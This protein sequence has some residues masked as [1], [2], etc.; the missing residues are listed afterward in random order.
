M[1]PESPRSTGRRVAVAALWTAILCLPWLTILCWRISPISYASESLGYRYFHSYRILNGDAST[2]WE[3]QGQVLG[4]FHNGL[5]LLIDRV[6]LTD[7]PGLRARLDLFAHLTLLANA[8]ALGSV[9]LLAARSRRILLVDLVTM[10]SVAAF[11]VFAWGGGFLVSY[12]PDYYVFEVSA[13]CAALGLALE[14]MR[15]SPRDLGLRRGILLGV[16]AAVLVALK[17]TLVPVALLPVVVMLARTPNPRARALLVA[18]SGWLVGLAAGA[19]LIV[20]AFYCFDFVVIKR[21]FASWLRYV[22]HPGESEPG[23]WVTWLR[24]PLGAGS[25]PWDDH[26]YFLVILAAWWASVLFVL[27]AA[28]ADDSR[29]LRRALLA[30]VLFS[31][32][33]HL[34]GLFKRPAGTT[35]FEISLFL[36]TSAAALLAAQ[37]EGRPRLR[38]RLCLCGVLLLWSGF[39]ACEGYPSDLSLVRLRETGEH[40][41]DL[42]RRLDELHLPTVVLIPDNSYTSG[43]VEEAL[44][45]GFSDVPTWNVT[46]GYALLARFAPNR[47]YVRRLSAIAPGQALVWSDVDGQ[48]PLEATVPAVKAMLDLPGV[49]AEAW[50]MWGGAAGAASIHVLVA[51]EGRAWN[52]RAGNSHFLRST[53]RSPIYGFS[54][55][56]D[57]KCELLYDE[58]GRPF[59]RVKA[60]RSC[61]RMEITCAM[62]AGSGDARGVLGVR[63]TVRL[64]TPRQVRVQL[65]AGP[66]SYSEEPFLA[67]RTWVRLQAERALPRAT[68]SGGLVSFSIA[69]VEE[70]GW[71]EISEFDLSLGGSP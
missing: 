15:G 43:N 5:N 21:A 44:L 47:R 56:E 67:G 65:R 69:D 59:V 3:A 32:A 38:A 6:F 18:L 66:W 17:I 9:L 11:G 71:F 31:A 8:A 52:S 30:L 39:A 64:D 53:Q 50:R 16:F 40:A 57:A 26:R 60:T 1:M 14:Y 4:A 48:P 24:D 36:T 61:P 68:R 19:G 45:K 42:H 23:F 37:A 54:S 41:W 49:R 55:T 28:R 12:L 22:A 2:I 70:G 46:G 51:P 20:S 7:N 62:P 63:A 25:R 29:R 10:G 58:A 35:V 27:L 33:L 13:N 34:L